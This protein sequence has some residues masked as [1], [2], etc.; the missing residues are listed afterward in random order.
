MVGDGVMDI[1]AGQS[2]GATTLLV[3]SRKCYTCESLAAH[4]TRPDYIVNSLR[5]AAS[6]ICALAHGEEQFVQ[7]FIYKCEVS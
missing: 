3:S 5:Q 4:N 2:A 6:V 1:Q 7:Q